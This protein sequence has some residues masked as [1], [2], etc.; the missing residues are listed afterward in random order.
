VRP[1]RI[2]PAGELLLLS[3]DA[4]LGVQEHMVTVTILAGRDVIVV[5]LVDHADH[6]AADHPRHR[7]A[8]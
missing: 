8:Q 6:L 1:D 3:D 5:T 4:P 7:L 2:R